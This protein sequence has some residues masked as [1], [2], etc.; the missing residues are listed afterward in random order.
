MRRIV[1]A[2]AVVTLTSVLLAAQPPDPSKVKQLST[3][4]LKQ[5]VD[6]KQKFF[7]LDVREP[8]EIEELGTLKGYVNIP[9]DQ[10]ESRI[11]EIP[12]DIQI[13]TA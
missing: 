6:G 4:E 2:A 5:L 11:A 13:V 9:I 10:L 7:F 12:R 3:D 8:G 1:I